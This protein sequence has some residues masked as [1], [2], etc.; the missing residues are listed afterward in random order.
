[1]HNYDHLLATPTQALSGVQR[2]SRPCFQY[3]FYNQT[4]LQIWI[5]HMD[6]KLS[7]AYRDSRLLDERVV[8][9]AWRKDR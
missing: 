8:D 7:Y 2:S 6:S 4:H 3:Y 5:E 1:M 9:K